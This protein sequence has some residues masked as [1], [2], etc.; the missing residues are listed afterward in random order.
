MRVERL[1]GSATFVFLPP[2]TIG[3]RGLA[4]TDPWVDPAEDPL[5][6][7][8][9]DPWRDDFGLG[10]LGCMIFALFIVVRSVLWKVLPLKSWPCCYD[11]RDSIIREM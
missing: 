1:I 7:P 6:D 11:S 5:D 3:L 4:L 2:T 8:F 9:E 10:S